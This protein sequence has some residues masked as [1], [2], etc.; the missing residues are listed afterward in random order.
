V[1]LGPKG[2]QIEIELNG[3]PGTAMPAW[4][5]MSDVEIASVI[6]YTRNSWGNKAP[7]NVVQPAEVKGERK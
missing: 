6:S 1:V 7:E 3:V 4:K 2:G 5:H